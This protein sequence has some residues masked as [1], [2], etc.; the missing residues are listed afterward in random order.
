MY[1][2]KGSWWY[3]SI[4]YTGDQIL[5]TTSNLYIILLMRSSQLN[6][7]SQSLLSIW[8]KL[9]RFCFSSSSFLSFAE[10]IM[11]LGSSREFERYSNPEIEERPS[12]NVEVPQ[13]IKELPD[14]PDKVRER[15]YSDPYSLK[16]RALI[17]AHL[18]RIDLPPQTLLKGIAL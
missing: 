5:L 9:K 12:D 13:L 15:P 8:I 17:Y 2:Q 10:A 4:K 18:S 16:A 6:I 1:K 11:I 3:K 14:L 7:K